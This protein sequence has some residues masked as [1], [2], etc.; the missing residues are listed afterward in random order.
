MRHWTKTIPHW[1]LYLNQVI[2]GY[3]ATHITALAQS[4]NLSNISSTHHKGEKNSLED[5]I[6]SKFNKSFFRDMVEN[7]ASFR[8]VELL[9]QGTSL[10]TVWKSKVVGCSKIEVNH[11]HKDQFSAL[12]ISVAKLGWN[13][14]Y[15]LQMNK[16]MKNCRFSPKSSLSTGERD[17]E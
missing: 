16:T 1:G 14:T 2:E 9:P 4:Q 17:V 10:L 8:H 11:G 6:W 13:R 5:V 12:S 3:L 7:M 15:V